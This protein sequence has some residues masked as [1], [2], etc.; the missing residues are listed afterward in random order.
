MIW[1]QVQAPWRRVALCAA[2]LLLSTFSFPLWSQTTSGS[3]SGTVVDPQGGSVPNATVKLTNTSTRAGSIASTDGS[4][5]FV[6]PS[7]LPSTYTLEVAVQGFK[8]YKQSGLVLNANSALPV[9][10]IQLQVGTIQ[11]STEVAA[12]GQQ[13]ETDTAQLSTSIVGKQLQNIQV[14]GRSPLFMF[15][16]DTGRGL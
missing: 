13:V 9:G 3:I 10:T 4:G 12:Q 5:R 2:S 14:N 11:E 16:H 8:T 15:A 7:L 1:R 6:F